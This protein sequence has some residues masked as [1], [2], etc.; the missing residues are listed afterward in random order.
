MSD[1]QS[2]HCPNCGA[3]ADPHAPRCSYCRARLAAISC[4][5]CF[6]LM[7][8]G[9]TFCPQCGTRSVRA[10]AQPSIARCPECRNS[11]AALAINDLTLLECPACDGVWVG[12][13]EFD[14]ICAEHETQAAVLN[15]KAPAAPSVRR[16]QIRYRPCVMCGK[17]MNRL[18]FGR[19][20][21]IVID[22]CRGHGAFLDPGELHAIVSF[23][24]AGGLDR[25]RQREKDDLEEER[26]RLALLKSQV[27][28]GTRLPE[29]QE[30]AGLHDTLLNLRRLLKEE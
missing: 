18:N 1:A 28:S 19:L 22:L 3:A 30:R 25:A 9:S 6:A 29:W 24:T 11:M 16:S 8:D 4:P 2:L 7:F 5:H 23:I 21:G 26:H 13:T 17:M 14:R 20:S 15:G 12:A 10:T 27:E